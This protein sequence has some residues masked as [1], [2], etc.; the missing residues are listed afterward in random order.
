MLAGK[1]AL[2]NEARRGKADWV[3]GVD[4]VEQRKQRKQERKNAAQ[5]AAD[6]RRTRGAQTH[7]AKLKADLALLESAMERELSMLSTLEQRG[8]PEALIRQHQRRADAAEDRLRKTETKLREDPFL[9][10]DTA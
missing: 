10:E 2:A 5:A 3:P 7:K 4:S 9:A 6:M 1:A 8:A